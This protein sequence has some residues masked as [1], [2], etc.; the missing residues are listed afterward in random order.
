MKRTRLSMKLLRGLLLK[1]AKTPA[2]VDFD[3]YNP[4]EWA[5]DFLNFVESSM[6][7]SPL[8]KP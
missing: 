8:E 4:A 1:Y 3:T 5:E 7:S 2:P 6:K